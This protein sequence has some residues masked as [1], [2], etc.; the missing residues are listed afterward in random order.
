MPS[1]FASNVNIKLLFFLKSSENQGIFRGNISF[2]LIPLKL[3]LI[4]EAKFGDNL[5]IHR[6]QY[7]IGSSI[8]MNT[9]LFIF[10]GWKRNFIQNKTSKV[11]V[12][13]VT[14][15]K[16]LVLNYFN[17]IKVKLLLHSCAIYQLTNILLAWL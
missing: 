3:R 15:Y 14:K 11:V 9:N 1:N 6:I 4:L 12:L 8:F 7:F 10:V 13:Q 16:V 2:W 5:L 17:Y